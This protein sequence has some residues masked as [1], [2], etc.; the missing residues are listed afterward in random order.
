MGQL[1]LG[2]ETSCDETSAAVVEE[3]LAVRSVV[4]ATQ[5]DLH[6]KYGGI[7]PEIASRAHIENLLPVLT[8]AMDR[9]KVNFS[10]L[11]AV[12]VA[13]RPG[14]IGSLVIGLTS[15]KTIAW[16]KSLPLVAVDHVLAHTYSPAL[17]RAL[18]GYPAMA[19]VV[20]G[21]HTSIYHLEG[22]TEAIRVGATT[23]DAA[24]EAFDKVAAILE[25]GFPGGPAI[26]RLA[27]K[28]DPRALKLPRAWL[29]KRSLDFSFSG[30]KTAVLYKVRGYPKKVP[31]PALTQ[32]GKAD[33]AASFQQAVLEVLVGKLERALNRYP[34]KMILCGGGVSANSGLRAGL[35]SLG[36]R[37]D[38]PVWMPPM[39]YCTDNAAMIA[40]LAHHHAIARDF[41]DLDVPALAT[42]TLPR[43]R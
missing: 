27:Q 26:D 6:A 40:G 19:L 22:P 29:G 14:L 39:T 32:Q 41:A 38:L 33:L 15:A 35:D 7:V 11:A 16:S 8:E 28:G 17:D 5:F 37:L 42:T 12:A 4:T 24:G 31:P 18:P 1:I 3:G 36:R 2:I 43:Q 30:I 23:D 20:S 13:N 21:G 9:A 10:D 25:L 34:A